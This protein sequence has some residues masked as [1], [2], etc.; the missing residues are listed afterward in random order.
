MHDIQIDHSFHYIGQVDTSGV[1][2]LVCVAIHRDISGNQIIDCRTTRQRGAEGVDDMSSIGQ[3]TLTMEDLLDERVGVIVIP[4]A[5]FEIVGHAGADIVDN[6]GCIEGFH[7]ALV[8]ISGGSLYIG[9]CR[10]GGN[11][12]EEGVVVGV[13]VVPVG[14]PGPEE[15]GAHGGTHA[16]RE[17]VVEEF[18]GGKIASKIVVEYN[19]LMDGVAIVVDIE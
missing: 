16:M 15:H 6:H 7:V 5:D 10:D 13:Y 1:V 4:E 14:A 9:E 18:G 11:L 17:G 19:M 2:C 8:N 3:S 12:S